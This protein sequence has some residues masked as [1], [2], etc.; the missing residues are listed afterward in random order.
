[1]MYKSIILKICIENIKMYAFS[2]IDIN[3]V[4]KKKKAFSSLAKM[5]KA[6]KIYKI[7]K[8]T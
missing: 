4:I 2:N 3:N 5:K 6:K 8:L 7:N 1:M